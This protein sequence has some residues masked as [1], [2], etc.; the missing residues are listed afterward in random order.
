[1]SYQERLARLNQLKSDLLRT[2]EL[3][4]FAKN[5][6]IIPHSYKSAWKLLNKIQDKLEKSYFKIENYKLIIQHF[7]SNPIN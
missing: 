5:I 4:I 1:M 6:P 3:L 7:K 2:Q